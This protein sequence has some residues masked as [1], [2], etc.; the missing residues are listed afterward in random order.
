MTTTTTAAA[1]A[2]A[3]TPP[4]P[5]RRKRTIG[6]TSKTF[7]WMTVPAVLLFFVLH[8]VPVLTGIFFSF[9]DYA[10]Y[11][12]WDLIGASNYLALLQ[13][14]RVWKAYGFTFGFAI[15]ATVLV[16]VISL[17]IA[18]ALSARIKFQ[19]A[20]RGIY[21]IP[22]VLS[23]LVIGY[24]FQYLFANS[25]PQ[26]LGAIPV[27]GENIL[28]NAD[29]AWVAIVV[30][31]V[32]QASAFSIIIYLA[33]LQTIPGELYEATSLDGAGRWRQF[34]SITFP[35]IASFFTINMVISMKN[36]LQVFDHIIA[37]T[38]GGP[39]T[40]T[41]SITLLIYRGGFQ[42]GEYAYQTANAVLYFLI[43]I[44]VSL[45]QFRVLS[46]REASF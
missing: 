9:T 39:G 21:F 19:T 5:A 45:I 37:L 42:G 25:L 15:V 33:G 8:T 12:S 28:A 2:V 23:T 41:E 44:V 35:L 16:N 32:W 13:D 14:D 43:I 10:G 18:V 22:Y 1:Q 11:G 40:S 24:V 7:Y 31:A 26:I 27:I 38:N 20:F 4:P 36:F 17:A 29:W 46:R 34:T 30:L 6:R 3:T